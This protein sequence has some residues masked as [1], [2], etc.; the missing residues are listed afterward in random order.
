MRKALLLTLIAAITT[1]C[2]YAQWT[3]NGSNIY[4]NAGNVGI[5]TTTPGTILHIKNYNQK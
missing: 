4:Y 1:R 5:G 2:C 3:P